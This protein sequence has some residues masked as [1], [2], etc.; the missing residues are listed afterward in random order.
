MS[1]TS[2]SP[3]T[4]VDYNSIV[5]S[6][7]EIYSDT[8]SG[9]T[10]LANGAGFG[11]GV[12]PAITTVNPQTN[13]LASEYNKLYNAINL[14]IE[15]QRQPLPAPQLQLYPIVTAGSNIVAYNSPKEMQE[16]VDNLTLNR[17]L[18][19]ADKLSLTS[20]FTESSAATPWTTSLI[21]NYTVNLGSWNNARYFFNTGGKLSI[22][23][24]YSGTLNEETEWSAL[25]ANIGS[26]NFNSTTSSN[27]FIGTSV[28][29]YQLTNSYTTLFT[30]TSAAGTAG[31]YSSNFIELSAKLANPPGTDGIINFKILLMNNDPT[32]NPK[33][34]TVVYNT[35]T[36]KAIIY[37][38]SVSAT[39]SGFTAS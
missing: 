29:F 32:P 13:I 23:G 10:T 26:I 17:F 25:L 34:G 3:I 2:G 33:T 1:Y 39:S 31:H 27:G 9:A 19:A 28:G 21:L 30:K 7:N 6:I 11:Y 20:N 35:S 16:V 15:H 4:A 22:N 18:V 5:N 12:L 8:H 14:I 37:P 24:S 38:G 36:T